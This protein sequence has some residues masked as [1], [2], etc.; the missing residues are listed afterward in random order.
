MTRVALLSDSHGD[1]QAI[2]ALL[3]KM[4][5][6]DA[7]CFMGDVTRDAMHLG[8]RLS[9][10][11]HRP[12]LYAVRG[13]NDY[14]SLYPD[15]RIAEIG[16]RKLYMT[17]GHLCVSVLSLA[18]RALERGADVALYGHTHAPFCEMVQGVLVIN[19]GSAGNHCRGGTARASVLMIDGGRMHVADVELYE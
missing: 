13:N 3:E 10:M 7:A 16:G 8:D 14:S 11:P 12:P 17:H 15:D 18:Y 1:W 9:Q 6:I 4:G 19:P 5:H 2:D